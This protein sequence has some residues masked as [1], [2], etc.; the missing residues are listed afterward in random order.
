MTKKE[1]QIKLLQNTRIIEDSII[2]FVGEDYYDD[3]MNKFEDVDDENYFTGI[4][5]IYLK[6]MKMTAKQLKE[7]K[8]VRLPFDLVMANFNYGILKGK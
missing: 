3:W 6:L 7:P 2:R 1:K 5:W 4:Y 8:K